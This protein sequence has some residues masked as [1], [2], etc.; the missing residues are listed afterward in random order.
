MSNRNFIITGGII[1]IVVLIIL[2]IRQTSSDN[3]PSL[4]T[5]VQNGRFEIA[6]TTTGELQAKTSV[7]IRGPEGLRNR[8]LGIREVKILDLVD[9]GTVLDSGDYVGE[10]DKTEVLSKLRDIEDE[11]EKKKSEYIKTKLD[12]AMELKDVRNQLV[13]KKYAVE[14]KKLQ[15]KQSKYEPQATKRQATIEYQRAKRELRQARENYSLRVEQAKARMRE[16]EINLAKQR[17]M[18]K[19]VEEMLKEFTIHAPQDGMVIYK[20]GWN[21]K[22]R[23]EGSTIS[24]WDLTVA[25]LPDLSSLVSKNFVNE[26][27]IS[28][29]QTGQHVKIQVDAFPDRTYRG[30]VSEVANI[31]QELKNTGAKVFEVLITLNETDSILRP[32]MT[33]S[34]RIITSVFK[35]VKYLPIEAVFSKDST[36]FVYTTYKEKKEI[37]TGASN[38]NHIIVEGLEPEE[39][40]YLNIPEKTGT[41]KE[42]EFSHK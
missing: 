21:G 42:K 1:V 10:L 17:R 4:V 34:N 15:M 36:H 8:S 23:K 6:V 27:D 41:F 5:T 33:T 35:D 13:D 3:T 20:K 22:K 16:V 7:Q 26:I 37:H 24:P 9:E 28:K 14:E 30:T 25:T 38:E 12:T 18:K 11:L 32:S 31:G 29:V 2:V 19:K 39:K 40:V